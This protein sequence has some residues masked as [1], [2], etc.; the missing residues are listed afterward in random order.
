[1]DAGA[2]NVRVAVRCRPLS[3]KE[4]ARGCQSIVQI[5]GKQVVIRGPTGGSWQRLCL[6]NGLVED[7][8]KKFTFDFAY[9]SFTLQDRGNWNRHHLLLI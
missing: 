5:D 2:V 9:D 1:M 4:L 3:S 6:L 8:D 7:K